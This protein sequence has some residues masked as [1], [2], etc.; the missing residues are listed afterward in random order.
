MEYRSLRRWLWIFFLFFTF[1]TSAMAEPALKPDA[2]FTYVVKP[3]DTLW[4]VSSRYLEQPWLW[5]QLY[6]ANPDLSHN[7]NRIYPGDILILKNSNGKARVTIQGR[8]ALKLSPKLRTEPLNSPIPTIPYADIKPFLRGILIVSEQQL[9]QDPYVLSVENEG[10]VAVS[11]QEFYAQGLDEPTQQDYYVYRKDDK[12]INP[13]NKQMIGYEAKY[14]GLAR[15]LRYRKGSPAVLSLMEMAE[16]IQPGDRL[17]TSPPLE[18]ASDI[19]L[20]EPIHRVEGQIIATLGDESQMVQHQIVV[21]TLGK[22]DQM[23]MGDVLAV[24]RPGSKVPDPYNSTAQFNKKGWVKLPNERMGE[25]VLFKVFDQASLGLIVNSKQ[26]IK[27]LD[28]VTN[29]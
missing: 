6:Q 13:K 20:R 17:I 26:E 18:H 10:K 23:R 22:Q 4:S 1:F 15:L 12:L 5:D 3:D 27:K 2:P 9:K 28:Q 14:I 21:I 19:L 25:I 16:E 7:P 8:K 24:Y 11:G 29:P